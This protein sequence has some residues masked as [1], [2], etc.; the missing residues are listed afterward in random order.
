MTP[1]IKIDIEV[2]DEERERIT[3]TITHAVQIDYQGRIAGSDGFAR[4]AVRVHVTQ[5]PISDAGESK[6]RVLR[7][8]EP[9]IHLTVEDDAGRLIPL[10]KC[11]PFVKS[12]HVFGVLIR[13]E[14]DFW[15]FPLPHGNG[16]EDILKATDEIEAGDIRPIRIH[17]QSEFC[18]EN[19]VPLS[20]FSD[21][22][23][24]EG[25]YEYTI[26][27]KP[28]LDAVGWW[29]D[30]NIRPEEPANKSEYQQKRDRLIEA[31]SKVLDRIDAENDLPSP[32]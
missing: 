30:L 23:A 14:D 2:T 13:R 11:E 16:D 24:A 5:D 31:I 15:I 20:A 32:A 1:E 6:P 18:V 28:I 7:K 25:E 19:A 8:D 27:D 22:D 17:G 10:E 9:G 26:E 12:E 3:R 21:G 4:Q 29:S